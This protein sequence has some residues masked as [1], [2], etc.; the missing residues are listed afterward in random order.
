[1]D[2]KI[3]TNSI[4]IATREQVSCDLAGEAAILDMKSGMYYGLNAVG[5]RIWSLLQEPKTVR[6][7]CATIVAEYDVEADPCVRDILA[8]LQE[9]LDR[10]L[11]EVRHEA[12]P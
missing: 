8:L 1:M 5:A 2:S 12:A 3:I 7:I 11:V 9:L 4:L 10:G 6:E